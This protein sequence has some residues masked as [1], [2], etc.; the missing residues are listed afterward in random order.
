MTT[1]TDPEAVPSVDESLLRQRR[2]AAALE[3][4]GAVRR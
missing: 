3:G 1:I 4:R 2:R